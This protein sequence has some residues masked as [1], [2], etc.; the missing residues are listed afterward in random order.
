MF[1]MLRA[2]A[3][4]HRGEVNLP[5]VYTNSIVWKV[6]WFSSEWEV[7]KH[8]SQHGFFI[9]RYP[10]V[11]TKVCWKLKKIPEGS[12][13]GLQISQTLCFFGVVVH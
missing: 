7:R 8:F 4:T 13:Y 10:N 1:V 3:R 6:M 11:I 2:H 9:S 12:H 5:D